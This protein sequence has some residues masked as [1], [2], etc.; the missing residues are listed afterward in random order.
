MRVSI[1]LND[2]KSSNLEVAAKRAVDAGAGETLDE[3]FSRILSGKNISATDRGR[4]E[5]VQAALE[6]GLITREQKAYEKG[7]KLSKAEVL[8]LY[9]VLEI[10][11]QQETLER[12]K[13]EMPDNYVLVTDN[14]VFDDMIR[15]LDMTNTIVFDVESTG[16]DVWSDYIVGHVISDVESDTHYYIPTKH[17]TDMPMLDHDYVNEKLKPYY[18]CERIMKIAHNS[19]FD[20]HMLRNEGITVKGELWDTQ[21]G[22]RLLNENEKSYALKTL[23]TK[24]L[25]IPSLTYGQLFGK[26]GFH[27]V[28]DLEIATAYAAKDGDVTYKL[29]EFQ[30]KHL[31]GSFPT[32]WKYAKEIEMPLIY[33]VVEL[34]RTG[35]CIDMEYADNY[36]IELQE[37]INASMDKLM[38]GLQPSWDVIQSQQGVSNPQPLN[39]N[40]S[41]QMKQTL[42]RVVGKELPNTNAKKTLKPLA[43]EYPIIAELLHYKE[44]TKL[45]GTYVSKLPHL[46]D[47]NTRKLMVHY[48]QN[49]AATGRF[50]SSGGVNIQN[51][52]PEARRLYVAPEGKVIIGADFK[53]Q[54]IRCVAYLS[55]EPVLINAF[56][57]KRDPYAMMASNFYD[58]P[59]DE[60]YKN[61]DGSDTKERKQMKVVWLATLYGMSSISLAEM[62]GTSKKDAEKLQQDLFASMPQLQKWIDDTKAF[63]KRHGFVWLDGKQRKRR[64]PYAPKRKL[65]IPYGSYNDPKFEKQRIF[66]SMISKS[67]RQ[68]PNAV[69]QGSSAIQTKATLIRLGQECAKREGW[70]LW[71]TVHDEIIVELPE[72]FTREDAKVIEDCMLYSYPWGDTV[73]NGTDLEVMRR[74]SDGMTVDD[75]FKRKQEDDN[76]D[77]I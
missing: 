24:Y 75:W 30:R 55:D 6:D 62:L 15:W 43:K 52:S 53:A 37:Q 69:V 12:M 20:I 46:I 77:E 49:G 33:T 76:Y 56:K 36:G 27:E 14:E 50:S 72:D 65:D 31:E 32:I 23:V 68:A 16:T 61:E 59:Y 58:K 57:E 73:A 13:A 2:S 40:S 35:F 45:Y 21:E 42:S 28:S 47:S 22:M 3:A 1:E 39:L 4:I 34:E 63:V 64:L 60:V 41:A 70:R 67:L 51:Q 7:R 38:D 8:R 54:E 5:R 29:Y 25:S 17:D 74:W 71:A 11:R 18:E 44:L 26:K 66:N 9:K 10:K 19:S 48:N